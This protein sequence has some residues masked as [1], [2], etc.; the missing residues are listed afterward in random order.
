[1]IKK[2]NKYI[3]L[4]VV[5]LMISLIFSSIQGTQAM[6]TM[7]F[8]E[9]I[10]LKSAEY[11]NYLKSNQ[12]EVIDYDGLITQY[13]YDWHCGFKFSTLDF[14]DEEYIRVV[15]DETFENNLRLVDGSLATDNLGGYI[16]PINKNSN[17]DIYFYSK[18]SRSDGQLL[19]LK[20]IFDHGSNIKYTA[21]LKFYTSNNYLIKDLEIKFSDWCMA[22]G[23]GEKRYSPINISSYSVDDDFVLSSSNTDLAD[24]IIDNDFKIE[25]ENYT[26]A[27]LQKYII[28]GCKEYDNDELL[29][30]SSL[31][32]QLGRNEILQQVIEKEISNKTYDAIYNLSLEYNSLDSELYGLDASYNT[33]IEEY[34]NLISQVEGQEAIIFE[35]NGGDFS[36]QIFEYSGSIELYL[37]DYLSNAV[38]IFE[39]IDTNLI[40]RNILE[41]NKDEINQMYDLQKSII[42]TKERIAKLNSI[43]PLLVT[44]I[45]K[46]KGV[47][48][49]IITTPS[50]ITVPGDITN[51]G[52]QLPPESPVTQEVPVIIPPAIEQPVGKE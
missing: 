19:A 12:P 14:K 39:E 45:E 41:N 52:E 29:Y 4:T 13:F 20:I 36:C 31:M 32:T 33:L 15:P 44:E 8:D 16:I 43:I 25:F 21:H 10:E 27:S 2:Y 18:M 42:T 48:G 49:T 6:Y 28:D 24:D 38:S 5:F 51:Q 7:S 1:M 9:T 50:A 11:N 17:K 37:N 40:S 46:L 35:D 30:T 22:T 47:I 23:F 34:N 3:K 26:V